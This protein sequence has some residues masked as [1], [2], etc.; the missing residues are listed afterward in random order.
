MLGP[1]SYNIQPNRVS[2][3]AHTL[4]C[5]MWLVLTKSIQGSYC[6]D[7]MEKGENNV[8]RNFREKQD[9]NIYIKINQTVLVN[10]CRES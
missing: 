5:I 9:R 3:K 10:C 8:V 6:I 4:L 2:L 1:N 7:K